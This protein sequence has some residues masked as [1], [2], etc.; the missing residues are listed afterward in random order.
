[1]SEALRI[2]ER[3]AAVTDAHDF[4]GPEDEIYTFDLVEILPEEAGIYILASIQATFDAT[5]AV[6]IGSDDNVRKHWEEKRK[7]SKF[8]LL[9]MEFGVE[10]IY[11]VKVADAKLRSAMYWNLRKKNKPILN[12]TFE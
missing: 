1:L 9:A 8:N 2:G 10:A 4:H 7:E 12:D 3:E 11:F 5:V 6:Y